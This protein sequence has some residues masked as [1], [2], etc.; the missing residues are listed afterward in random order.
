MDRKDED[1][2][3]QQVSK[4]GVGVRGEEG[5]GAKMICR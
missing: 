4:A 2:R 3:R 1:L 5:G